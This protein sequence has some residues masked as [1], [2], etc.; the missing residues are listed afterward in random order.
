M[1]V[2]DN[3]FKANNILT[4]QV[5][6]TQEDLNDRK[7]YLNA[8]ATLH[9]LL[10][11]EAVPIVNENDTISTDEIKF[12]DNDK[13]S[14][15]VANLI[16]A[17]LLVLLSNVDGLYRYD[18]LKRVDKTPIAVVDKI[19]SEI[20]AM[21]QEGSDELGTGGM[22]SKLQAAKI[23]ASSGIPCV[24]ANGRKDNIL[25][26]IIGGKAMGTLFLPTSV[27][28][29]AR[30]SWIGFGARPKGSI[31]IDNGAKEALTKKNKSLLSSGIVA[32]NGEFKAND[33]IGIIDPE[34]REFARGV[35][36]Y[37]SREIDKIKGLKTSEI[38]KVLGYKNEDE[39][40]HK[41]N[42]VIL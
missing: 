7:R 3:F 15:L 22:S 31:T 4:A 18:G 38:H 9:T 8:K 42:L 19:T 32:L 12:G 25:T 39:I 29:T 28:M 5:L 11:A 41:D 36:N 37:S 10:E 1:Q 17:D 2:Y 24:M 40:I 13:L 23:A 20:E 6:L 26:D 30:K 35:A 16:E 27:K 33:I 14:S 34:A 21:A